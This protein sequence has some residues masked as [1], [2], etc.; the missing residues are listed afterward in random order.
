MIEQVVRR[1]CHYSDRFDDPNSMYKFYRIRYT[2]ADHRKLLYGV[3]I[4]KMNWYGP[5]LAAK[6]KWLWY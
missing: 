6:T 5:A 2:I 3:L 4:I 1:D